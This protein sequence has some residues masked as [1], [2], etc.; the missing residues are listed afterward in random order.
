[1]VDA[2]TAEDISVLLPKNSDAAWESKVSLLPAVQA[3]IAADTKVGEMIYILEGA[4]VGRVDLVAAQDVPKA[5]M[6]QMLQRM[7]YIWC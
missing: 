3:P 2:V 5:G 1:M 7:L 6:E 4:E